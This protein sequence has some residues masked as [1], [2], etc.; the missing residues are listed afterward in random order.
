MHPHIFNKYKTHKN[1]KKISSACCTSSI[2]LREKVRN[3]NLCETWSGYGKWSECNSLCGAGTQVRSRSI[4]TV[5][6]AI[7]ETCPPLR[8]RKQQTRLCTGTFCGGGSG[9]LIYK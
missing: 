2:A 9:R 7:G 6:R 3:A 8:G 1:A 5:K 4:V